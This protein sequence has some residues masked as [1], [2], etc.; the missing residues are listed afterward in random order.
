M[1]RSAQYRA[2]RA[3]VLGAVLLALATGGGCRRRKAPPRPPPVPAVAGAVES[4]V[5]SWYGYPYHGRLAAN[6]EVYDMEQLTAA[7]RTLPFGTL[8][9]VDNLDNGRAV[10]VRITDRGPFIDGRI[11]DLSR[12]AARAIGM[13]G[14]GTAAVRIV[15][16][17]P[18]P[19]AP[20]LFTVQVGAFRELENAERLRRAVEPRY[21]PVRLVRRDGDPPLWRVLVGSPGSQIEAAELAARVRSEFGTAFVVRSDGERF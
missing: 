19:A 1:N 8:V 13:I 15:V 14:P 17:A 4:G 7:H 20:E 3:A 2:C 12:A 21:A 9:R 10:E 6:G 11:I 16:I 18:P 5:A